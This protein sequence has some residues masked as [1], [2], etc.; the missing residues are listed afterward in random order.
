MKLSLLPWLRCPECGFLLTL[1]VVLQ[2]GAEVREGSLGCT[3]CSKVFPIVN[4]IPRFVE[5]DGYADAF[6]YEWNVHQTT[7]LD[8]VSGR[9]DSEDRLRQTVG[10]PLENLK[11]K[12][13]LDVGCGTGRFAEIV[14]KYGGTVIGLDLSFAVDAAYKN[15]GEHPEMHIV[16]AD[17][18]KLP[19]K[20]NAFDVIYS[21]GVLHHTPDCQKAFQQLPKHLARGG[22]VA[23]TVYAGA[24]KVYVAS[25]NFWRR[26][27]TKLPKW[28]LYLLAHLAIPLYFLYRVPGLYHL[29]IGLFP[30][31][32]DSDWRW[33][34]LDTFDCYAP[35]YQSYHTYPEVFRW[36]EEAGL[37]KIR[38]LEPAVTVIG[39]RPAETNALPW[40]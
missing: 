14:L 18:F 36:F 31:S 3:F 9:T 2:K 30:I 22:R 12:L 6:S 23:V 32:M 10:F 11:G 7:Q 39:E 37:S 28:V 29:G 4:F 21:L 19:L 34:V 26:F 20:R 27:T 13:V 25:T 15:M 5:G 16:Q 33:R 38:I 24:N 35:T 17:V 8:S 1:E 40:E